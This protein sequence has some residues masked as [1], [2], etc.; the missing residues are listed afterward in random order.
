MHFTDS[1]LEVS[2]QLTDVLDTGPWILAAL[3]AVLMLPWLLKDRR[4]KTKSLQSE[5]NKMARDCLKKRS[6][7]DLLMNC[8]LQFI[9]TDRSE[10]LLMANR[11]GDHL[12]IDPVVSMWHQLEDEAA[13]SKD[14][15]IR[16]AQ[17][18]KLAN[19]SV[20]AINDMSELIDFGL[21]S[22]RQFFRR[23]LVDFES[24][25]IELAFLEP[26]IWYEVVVTGR[27]R[28]GLRTVQLAR[29]L[30]QMS[31]E[32]SRILMEKSKNNTGI[33]IVI[34]PG[35]N[36]LRRKLRRIWRWFCPTKINRRS[37]IKQHKQMLYLEMQFI[38]KGYM[39]KDSNAPW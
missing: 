27:G 17:A 26:Y 20:N 13:H 35:E 30:R 9:P 29:I 25:L 32:P 4:N 15:A 8:L 22:P 6:D 3:F 14:A 37:K 28:W 23:N 2:P 16:L 21:V 19:T 39:K 10:I 34:L 18:K 5:Y 1:L 12:A 36:L 31:S 24:L 7:H 11:S 38:E 33:E